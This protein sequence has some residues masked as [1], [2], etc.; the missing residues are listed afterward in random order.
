[1]NLERFPYARLASLMPHRETSHAASRL[2]GL[3]VSEAINRANKLTKAA[4][5]PK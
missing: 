5:K 4:P 3:S 1:M 2:S